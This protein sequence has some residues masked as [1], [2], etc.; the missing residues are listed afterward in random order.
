MPEK[1]RCWRDAGGSDPD[2]RVPLTVMGE[3]G[4]RYKQNRF[5]QLRGFCYA[6]ATGSVTA[7]KAWQLLVTEAADGPGARRPGSF[8]RP[9]S[10]ERFSAATPAPAS[11]LNQQ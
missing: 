9:R 10:P 1:I 11:R 4:Y 2:A 8:G 5:Q 3:A 7:T 6:A